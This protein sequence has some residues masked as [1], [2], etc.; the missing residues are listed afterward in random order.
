MD[1]EDQQHENMKEGQSHKY[2]LPSEESLD[3][4]TDEK[5]NSDKVKDYI[6]K[7][8]YNSQTEPALLAAKEALKNK[9]DRELLFSISNHDDHQSI[10]LSIEVTVKNRLRAIQFHIID[11]GKTC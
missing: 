5:A 10:L 8:L 1:P 3:L 7:A 4:I 11:I 9:H 2:G 6:R